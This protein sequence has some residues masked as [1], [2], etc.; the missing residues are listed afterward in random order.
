MAD[1]EVRDRAMVKFGTHIGRTA[2]KSRLDSRGADTKFSGIEPHRL[3]ESF[4]IPFREISSPLDM[5]NRKNENSPKL[6]AIEI[7]MNRRSGT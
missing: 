5:S 2:T 6:L 1:D 4:T 3:S 7:L